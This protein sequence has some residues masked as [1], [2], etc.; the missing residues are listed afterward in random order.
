MIV[1][2]LCEIEIEDCETNVY[3]ECGNSQ[4]DRLG[5]RIR[6]SEVG[7]GAPEARGARGEVFARQ[8]PTGGAWG[9]FT[10]V[11]AER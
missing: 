8:H 9:G 5:V 11:K 1:S 10:K 2:R 4:Q 3:Q 7:L 6:E